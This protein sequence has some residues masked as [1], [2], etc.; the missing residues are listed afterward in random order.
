[1][2]HYLSCGHELLEDEEGNELYVTL[3]LAATTCDHDGWKHAVHYGSYC[4]DCAKELEEEGL[5][6]HTVQE[7][8][9]WLSED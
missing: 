5:V 8:M 7:E 9:D 3:T 6:L 4:P 1:M 2:T